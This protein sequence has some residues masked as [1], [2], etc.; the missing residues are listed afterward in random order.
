MPEA[1]RLRSVGGICEK[2]QNTAFEFGGWVAKRCG[3]KRSRH[4][5][6]IGFVPQ[7]AAKKVSE[8]IEGFTRNSSR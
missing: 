2:V 6:P 4:E 7:G 8:G 1:S 5:N 3:V